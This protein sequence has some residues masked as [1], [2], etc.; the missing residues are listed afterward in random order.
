MS[1]FLA[2]LAIVGA[3][4]FGAAYV[5]SPAYALY[6]LKQAAEARDVDK[7]ESLVDM[8]AVRENLKKQVDSEITKAARAASSAGWSPLE[9][10]GKAGALWGDRKIKKLTQ[11]ER[12]ARMLSTGEDAANLDTSF[13]YLTLDRVR[14]GVAEKGKPG[15]PLRLIMERRGLFGW[16]VVKIELPGEE[17][18]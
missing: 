18:G 6:Q 16:K 10:I 11:A 12:L 8:P 4:L 7:L 17:A 3:L 14:V 5:A 1:K 9:A 2:F 15:E 13:D